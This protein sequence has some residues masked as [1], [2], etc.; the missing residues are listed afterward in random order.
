VKLIVPIVPPSANVYQ[1]M[2]WAQKKRLR[3]KFT[4]ALY[5]DLIVEGAGVDRAMAKRGVNIVVHSKGERVRRLDPDYLVGCKALIDSL[6]DIGLIVNDSPK[7]I[8]LT[9]SECREDGPFTEI[10]INDLARSKG[11]EVVDGK[12]K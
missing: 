12:E 1:R 4:H 10:E 3:A 7:W 6:K 5:R 11:F 2:H 8:D 9:V